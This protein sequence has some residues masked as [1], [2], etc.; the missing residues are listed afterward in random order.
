MCTINI[1]SGLPSRITRLHLD[2]FFDEG[3]PE[4]RY[5]WPVTRISLP[6]L[7]RAADPASGWTD[8]PQQKLVL[9]WVL[10]D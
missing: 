9:C 6:N 4:V 3:C 7:G 8:S 5:Y 10:N 2:M 1:I